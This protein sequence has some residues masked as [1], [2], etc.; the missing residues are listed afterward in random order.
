VTGRVARLAGCIDDLHVE[1]AALA[2][3]QRLEAGRVVH[4]LRPD[5]RLLAVARGARVT[6][7]DL[8]PGVPAVHVVSLALGGRSAIGG[9]AV[10]PVGQFLVVHRQRLRRRL[11]GF[12]LA[13]IAASGVGV[14]VAH[15]SRSSAGSWIQK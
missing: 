4:V 2:T 12:G 10:L 8:A 15:R 1:P 7:L 13:G 14:M 11:L 6:S 5:A 3:V 9:G